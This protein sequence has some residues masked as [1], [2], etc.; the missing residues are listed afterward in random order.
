MTYISTKAKPNKE[1]FFSRKR[2]K[3]IFFVFVFGKSRFCLSYKEKFA[4]ENEKNTFSWSRE[5]PEKNRTRTKHTT[6]MFL[7]ADLMF[8]NN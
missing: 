1:T 7:E 5:L 6:F 3:S 8:E 2:K 4:P